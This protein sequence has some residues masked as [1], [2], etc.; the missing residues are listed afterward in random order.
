MADVFDGIRSLVT[1]AVLKGSGNKKGAS[2]I[3]IEEPESGTDNVNRLQVILA[4]ACS[5]FGK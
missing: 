3:A 1:L 2:G 4:V 5:F